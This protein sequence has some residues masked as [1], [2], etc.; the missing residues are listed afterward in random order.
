[1]C[2]TTPP[3]GAC[4]NSHHLPTSGNLCI[5][6]QADT[7]RHVCLFSRCAYHG[8]FLLQI[9]IESTYI[10]WLDGKLHCMWLP[11]PQSTARLPSLL[12]TLLRP[13]ALTQ[14]LLCLLGYR[15]WAGLCPLPQGWYDPSFR[16][17]AP[18][19]RLH[20]SLGHCP[21]CPLSHPHRSQQ[22]LQLRL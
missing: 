17:Q 16:D 9:V 22:W 1:M 8:M 3:S 18:A 21:P 2:K 10:H 14:P 15:P 11:L 6:L 12:R 19:M 5:C 13:L 7:V 20:S 4:S